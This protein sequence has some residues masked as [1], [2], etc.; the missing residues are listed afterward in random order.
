MGTYLIGIDTGTQG[1]KGL[2]QV[3]KIGSRGEPLA[4]VW[5]QGSQSLDILNLLTLF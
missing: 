4:G 2:Y 5:G 1:T 3:V